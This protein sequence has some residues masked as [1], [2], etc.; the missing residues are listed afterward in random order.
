MFFSKTFE[1]KMNLLLKI[2]VAL[3]L[4]FIIPLIFISYGDD[5]L[6]NVLV[7]FVLPI[8]IWAALYVT[9]DIQN[10]VFVKVHSGIII[11]WWIIMVGHLICVTIDGD[12]SAMQMSKEAYLYLF[13]GAAVSSL[14]I[15]LKR[16]QNK[17]TVGTDPT[18][19]T[20]RGQDIL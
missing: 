1:K 16:K 8:W 6:F 18:V 4:L 10:P 17:Y 3:C 19:W 20:R 7:W 12:G 13:I 2:L 14:I 9:I 15:I 11:L 5:K